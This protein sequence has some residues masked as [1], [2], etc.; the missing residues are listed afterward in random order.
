MSGERHASIEAIWRIEG[1]RIIA[2]LTRMVGDVGLAVDRAAGKSGHRALDDEAGNPGMVPYLL[3]FLICPAEEKEM[4][5]N[6]RERDPHL[7]AV[8]YPIVP[9]ATS[10]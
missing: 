3:L 1:S 6:V 5:R 7:L 8:Q 2:S 4:I 10:V 9:I